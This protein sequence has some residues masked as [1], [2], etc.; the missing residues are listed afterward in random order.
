MAI[1]VDGGTPLVS[2]RGMAD[3]DGGVPIDARTRFDLA[4]VSKWFTAAAVMILVEQ[5]RLALGDPVSRYVNAHV[6]SVGA[7]PIR[8]ADLLGHT[9]GLPD[10]LHRGLRTPLHQMSLRHVLQ[11]LPAWSSRARPGLAHAY[12]NT[13]FV[14]LGM[15]LEDVCGEPFGRI[16]K[17]LLFEPHG[18]VATTVAAGPT[19]GLARGYINL[20]AGVS[21]YLASDSLPVDTVGDG[22]I[23]ST[24]DDM[25]RWS[26]AFWRGQVVSEASLRL[27]CAPG[28]LDGGETFDYGL[29]LQV[30][31]RGRL[32]WF[33]HG[34]SWTNG[35]AIAGRYPEANADIIILSN[36]FAAPVER[37]S[38][39]VHDMITEGGA[40]LAV[41]A[42]SEFP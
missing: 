38:Q 32:Q 9:S 7:R 3:I 37:I 5:G 41:E 34:G 12:S 25:L 18:M 20:G 1:V 17:A 29:G 26:A 24:I 33:G 30:Q 10:Y 6:D 8:V 39:Q 21:D 40:G 42:R 4:S 27:M 22:G 11:R 28:R 35:V 13:N 19:P 2:C 15:V 36:E 16:L 23:T 31:T 14:L